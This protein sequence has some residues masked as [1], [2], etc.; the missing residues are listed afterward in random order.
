MSAC[1]FDGNS[2]GSGGVDETYVN[3]ALEA[4]QSEGQTYTGTMNRT[5]QAFYVETAR[6]AESLDELKAGVPN[7]TDSYQYTTQ[8]IAGKAVSLAQSQNPQL[9]SFKGIIEIDETKGISR[10]ALCITSE[11]RMPAEEADRD[12]KDPSQACE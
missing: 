1:S 6:F 9:R 4:Q 5:Q 12:A 7:T 8:V 10:S 2:Q 11:P 3:Q